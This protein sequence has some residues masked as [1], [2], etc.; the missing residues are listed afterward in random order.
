[1]TVVGNDESK[2]RKKVSHVG[3]R[4]KGLFYYLREGMDGIDESFALLLGI[5]EEGRET[6]DHLLYYLLYYYL[7][8]YYLL[9]YYLLY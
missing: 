3:E 6:I 5:G 4:R 8:Y 9:Y 1:M 2:E 7:L